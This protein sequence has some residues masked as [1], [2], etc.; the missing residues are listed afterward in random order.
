V[1]TRDLDEKKI[2]FILNNVKYDPGLWKN[3][4]SIGKAM[5]EE[6]TLESSGKNMVIKK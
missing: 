6:A 1:K 5:K 4:F 2:M 3:L